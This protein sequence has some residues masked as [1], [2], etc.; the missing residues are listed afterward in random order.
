MSTLAGSSKGCVDGIGELAKFNQPV[1]VVLSPDDNCLYV[2]DDG[3]DMIRKVTL[4]GMLFHYLVSINNSVLYLI[5]EVN[6]FCKVSRPSD[7]VYN[8][9]Q[10]LFYVSSYFGHTIHQITYEGLPPFL[11]C[12]EFYVSFFLQLAGK[13]SLFAGVDG[14]SGD[15]MV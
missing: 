11:T 12:L 1:G 15:L 5:G 10:Q 8:R 3:N 13:I 9:Q 7:I 2:C 6:E 4:F 14:K